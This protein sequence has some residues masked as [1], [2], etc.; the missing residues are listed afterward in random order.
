[1]V[2]PSDVCPSDVCPADVY[3]SDVYPFVCLQNTPSEQ[4]PD[5]AQQERAGG[6]SMFGKLISPN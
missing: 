1:M 4:M 2:C 6:K 5:H 3:P